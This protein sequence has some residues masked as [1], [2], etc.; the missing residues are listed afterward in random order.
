[1]LNRVFLLILS[2]AVS[3]GAGACATLD[4]QQ[5][6]SFE[7][8]DGF[9][10]QLQKIDLVAVGLS[11]YDLAIIDYSKDGH[12][13]GEWSRDQIEWLKRS[14]KGKYALAYISIGEAE[15]YRFYWSDRW[16]TGQPDWLGRENRSW[17]GN[18][19]V[20][21]WNPA[22]QRIVFSYLD[23]IIDQGF[24][25][26]YMDI[27]DGFWYWGAEAARRGENEQLDSTSE[28]AERMI[29]FV[30]ALAHHS[31]VVRGRQDFILCPQNGTDIIREAD[32][33]LVKAYLDAIDAIGVEDTF[34]FGRRD[35]NN[36][37][38]PQERVIANL[39]EFLARDKKVLAVEYLKPDNRK[40][41]ERFYDLCEQYG[42]IP[43]ASGRDLDELR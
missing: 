29:E 35:E 8:I 27:I 37:Y 36:R 19:K 24:D 22:W 32:S 40:S 30:L 10:Y 23:R 13:E 34:F 26:I 33:G 15:S 25:G 2:I 14:G 16:K 28:A 20:K 18:Y 17:K 31:R 5:R 41:I 42:Y 12:E 6:Q 43:F 1:M 38:K 21:Y 3:L 4:A 39:E 7:Q 9:L 11:D